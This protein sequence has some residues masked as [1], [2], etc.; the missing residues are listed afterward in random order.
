MARSLI[1]PGNYDFPEPLLPSQIG[2]SKSLTQ[3][4]TQKDKSLPLRK[5]ASAG[6][7][8]RSISPEKSRTFVRQQQRGLPKMVPENIRKDFHRYSNP[9]DGPFSVKNVRDVSRYFEFKGYIDGGEYRAVTLAQFMQI[10][11]YI[12]AKI[13]E[14]KLTLEETNFYNINTWLIQPATRATN[15][16]LFE[17]IA[18]REQAPTWFLSH[19]WGEPLINVMKCVRRHHAARSLP[20]HVAY[21]ICAYACRQEDLVADF[22]DGLQYNDFF[23]AMQQARFKVLLILDVSTSS[24]GPATPFKRL[25]CI[26]ECSM[27]LDQVA[28]PIDT[29]LVVPGKKEEVEL[30]CSGLTK[31]ERTSDKYLAGRGMATKVKREY[32]FPDEIPKAGLAFNVKLATA[33]SE[34]DHRRILNFIAGQ[35]QDDNPPRDHERYDRLNKRIQGLLSQLFWHRALSKDKPTQEEPRKK[36]M[37]HLNHLS[38]AIASDSWRRSLSLCL[39]GCNLQDDDSVQLVAQGVPSNLASL[40]L[41]LQHSGVGDRHLDII[42]SLLPKDLQVL[43]LD[44]SGCSVSD[45]GIMSFVQNLNKNVQTLSLG[46]HSTQ[47]G[48]FLLEVTKHEPL[49]TLRERAA[50]HGDKSKMKDPRSLDQQS[51]DRQ[52]ML[53][54]MLRAKPHPE[55]RARIISELIAAGQSGDRLRMNMMREEMGE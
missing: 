11:A 23:R 52:T 22:A 30:V 43:S 51:E 4:G 16:A 19:W 40:S 31:L 39:A 13:L 34:Q 53:E 45:A 3:L 18:D 33:S 10:Y 21:W 6:H 25:W 20:T 12:E 24:G 49:K 38:K 50:A 14:W 37:A 7:F 8:A 29:A 35:P 32:T 17:H 2:K 26:F 15:S 41:N 36:F 5:T 55:V 9:G 54:S 28:A 46:L 42:A 44:L 27:C 47:V 48:A 1:N